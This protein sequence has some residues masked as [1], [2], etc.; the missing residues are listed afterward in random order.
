MGTVYTTSWIYTG[1]ST[2]PTMRL[3][4]NPTTITVWRSL[5]QMSLRLWLHL[6]SWSQSWSFSGTVRQYYWSDQALEEKTQLAETDLV[7]NYQEWSTATQS[8][9]GD[10]STA[11][12]E[13]NSLADTRGNGY[14]AD[15]LQMMMMMIMIKTLI[16]MEYNIICCWNMDSEEGGYTAT[17]NI[18]DVEMETGNENQLDRTPIQSRSFG[19]AGWK[20]RFDK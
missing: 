11:C 4:K 6:Q 17:G 15:K 19:Y 12:S 13:Q 2:S 3:I 18:W 16:W 1:Q 9:S 5:L 7:T 10:S 8:G 14:I 20:Q